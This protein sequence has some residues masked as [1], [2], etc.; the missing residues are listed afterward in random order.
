MPDDAAPVLRGKP[1]WVITD[2][3]AGHEIQMLG[4]VEALGAVP[5]LKPIP[6]PG[7]LYKLTAP[8]GPVPRSSRFGAPGSLFAPPWPALALATGRLT[9]PYIRA[10]KRQAGLAT[11]T[12]VLLDPK[13]GSKTADLFWV[14][15]HDRRRG[16]NVITTATSPHRYSPDRLAQLRQSV[17]PALAALPHPRVA[18]LL[19]GPNGDYRYDADDRARLAQ[20]LRGLSGQGAG[21]MITVS[22][23]TPADLLEAA[24]A[25]IAGT[26]SFLWTGEG[27]NPYPA[28]LAHADAFVVTAD[29]VNMTGEAAATGRPIHVF[30]PAGGS[31]KFDRFHTALQAAGITRPITDAAQIHDRWTYTP[32]QSA[33]VIAAEVERR[34]AA[35]ARFIPGLTGGG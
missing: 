17:P 5:V 31:A 35:R 33:A 3:K 8:Y 29:S 18:V 21:L 34:L 22:R 2:G 15:E 30:R 1:V 20:L 27:E 10:L 28:F 11:F 7:R 26:P 12:L 16:P 32:L 14:P 6:T 24:R 9:T 13:T 4:I 19:G 23:R 25:A